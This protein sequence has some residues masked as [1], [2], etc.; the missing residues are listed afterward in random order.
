MVWSIIIE[1]LQPAVGVKAV[2][3]GAGHIKQQHWKVGVAGVFHDAAG[4]VTISVACWSS[5][6]AR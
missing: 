4:L 3:L 2:N 5:S 6:L 1:P